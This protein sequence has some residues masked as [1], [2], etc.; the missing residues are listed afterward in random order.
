MTP[1]VIGTAIGAAALTVGKSA[2][3]AVN[4]GLSFAS[5]LVTPSSATSATPNKPSQTSAEQVA[6]KQRSD[7]L[8][9]QIQQ[10]LAASGI[11]LSEPVELVSD[12]QG[13]ITLAAD[14]PQAAAIQTA[15]SSDILLERDFSM[16][17]GDYEEFVQSSGATNMSPTLVLSVPKSA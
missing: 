15:L 11:Q 2:V 13:G 10:Q 6:L 3:G 9:Q 16:L 12:G 5:Q 17:S 14:H 1:V 4:N 7:Q 8:S